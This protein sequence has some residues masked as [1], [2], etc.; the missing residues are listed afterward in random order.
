M[1]FVCGVEWGLDRWKIVLTDDIRGVCP[2]D[3]TQ[4]FASKQRTTLDLWEAGYL[5]DDLPGYRC[6]DSRA[7]SS[8]LSDCLEVRHFR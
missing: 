7:I 5:T 4:T 6:V 8:R 1:P 2:N 3:S